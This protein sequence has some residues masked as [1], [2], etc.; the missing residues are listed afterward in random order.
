[1]QGCNGVVEGDEN[2]SR[3]SRAELPP[4]PSTTNC[5]PLAPGELA[6]PDTLYFCLPV[7]MQVRYVTSQAVRALLQGVPTWLLWTP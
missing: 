2:S 5:L 6:G 4:L 3:A 1:M 7:R